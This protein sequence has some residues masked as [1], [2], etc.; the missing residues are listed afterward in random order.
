MANN[1]PSGLPAS[2][3]YFYFR[4]VTTLATDDGDVSDGSTTE[5]ATS[6]IVPVS[7]FRGAQPSDDNTVILYFDPI[8]RHD[9]RGADSVKNCDTVALRHDTA[10]Q[11]KKVLTS[12][13]EAAAGKSFQSQSMIV[14]A[15]DVTSTY[16]E[17]VSGIG[18][19]TINPVYA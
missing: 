10:N 16:L 11:A 6:M 5:D 14:V 17:G 12:I 18:A 4:T 9:D 19:I 15:D 8:I 7:A 1:I 2:R 3:K 13:L